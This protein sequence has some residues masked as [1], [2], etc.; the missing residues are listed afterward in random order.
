MQP[1]IA[2]TLRREVTTLVFDQ[3]GTVVRIVAT[4]TQITTGGGYGEFGEMAARDWSERRPVEH[5]CRLTRRG[6]IG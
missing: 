6:G 5:R 2:E 3:Y 1:P 4:N